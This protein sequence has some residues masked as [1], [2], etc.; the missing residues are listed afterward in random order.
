[1][2]AIRYSKSEFGKKYPCSKN[3]F[4]KNHQYS[5]NEFNKKCQCN[6][7]GFSKKHQ[8]RTNEFD[9]SEL[10]KKYQYTNRTLDSLIS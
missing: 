1:M 7:N 6:N 5:K 4:R 10:S 2:P 8:Y 9:D 3:G